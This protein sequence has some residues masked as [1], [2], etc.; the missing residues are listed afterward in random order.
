MICLSRNG[1]TRPSKLVTTIVLR[2]A[3]TAQ[4]YGRKKLRMRPDGLVAALGRHGRDVA[5]GTVEHARHS[6]SRAAE[7]HLVPP[8]MC[9]SDPST[10]TDLGLARRF[11]LLASGADERDAAGDRR[12]V[13]ARRGLRDRHAP[14]A[15]ERGADTPREADAAGDTDAAADTDAAPGS[16]APPSAGTATLPP[17]ATS[18]PGVARRRSW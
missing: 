4:R 2:T 10:G 7:A 9:C 8:S 12:H 3:Y 17:E 5:T 11:G 6:P 14:A 18:T 16:S 13:P 1:L 15:A